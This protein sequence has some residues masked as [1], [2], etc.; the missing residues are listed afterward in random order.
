MTVSPWLAGLS[1][2]LGKFS[3]WLS[4]FDWAEVSSSFQKSVSCWKYQTITEQKKCFTF[5]GVSTKQT[6]APWIF[7]QSY[8]WVRWYLFCS[9]NS[10]LQYICFLLVKHCGLDCADLL[11]ETETWWIGGPQENASVQHL[12]PKQKERRASNVLMKSFIRKV[13]WKLFCT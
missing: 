10:I 1:E 4:L 7:F 2:T 8:H 9:G 6:A 13:L 5:L 12:I 11:H 3:V